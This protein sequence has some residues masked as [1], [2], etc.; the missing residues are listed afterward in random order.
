MKSQ[1][2]SLASPLPPSLPHH[3]PPL[4]PYLNV[5][6]SI[7]LINTFLFRCL[8]VCLCLCSALGCCRGRGRM[9]Y[10]N[11]KWAV[12]LFFRFKIISES[13]SR[14]V[15]LWSIIISLRSL[16]L[17]LCVPLIHH[18]WVCVRQRLW[19]MRWPFRWHGPAWPSL[20]TTGLNS[21]HHNSIRLVA[22]Q[23]GMHGC[24]SVWVCKT[25]QKKPLYRDG[26]V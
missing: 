24:L 21:I 17:P 22:S 12:V 8:C 10:W 26:D 9:M 18:R 20:D 16:I 11:G 19:I 2:L 1:N 23:A 14:S 6:I 13:S 5:S 15:C 25:K 7:G 4:P 3:T